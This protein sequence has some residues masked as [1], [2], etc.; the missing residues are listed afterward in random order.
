MFTRTNHYHQILYVEC[1]LLTLRTIFLL[2]KY[3]QL[4]I[5]FFI[6]HFRVTFSFIFQ[7]EKVTRMVE[8][9]DK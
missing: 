5:L 2:L 7:I 3:N 8:R 9:L 6:H 4:I 1:N